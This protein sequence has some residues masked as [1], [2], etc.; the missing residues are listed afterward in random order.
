M[1]R[2]LQS[3][4]AAARLSRLGNHK[5]HLTRGLLIEH[6]GRALSGGDEGQVA[7]PCR[8]RGRLMRALPGGRG[9]VDGAGACGLEQSSR[10][11]DARLLSE[12]SCR[13]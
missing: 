11:P 8:G 12:P 5:W 6:E 4:L 3:V 7:M 9:E 1:R 10:E 2:P 13:S